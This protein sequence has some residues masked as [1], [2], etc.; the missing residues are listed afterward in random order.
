M[1]FFFYFHLDVPGLHRISSKS[2]LQ[3]PD[4]NFY[5]DYLQDLNFLLPGLLLFCELHHIYL[6]GDAAN[7]ANLQENIG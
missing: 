5:I 1:K 3:V 7:L 2:I 4:H 6:H